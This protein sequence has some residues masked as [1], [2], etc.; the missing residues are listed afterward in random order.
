MFYVELGSIL[1]RIR[2]AENAL[3]TVRKPE[4]A[5]AA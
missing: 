3:K 4:L 5:I 1:K 2:T